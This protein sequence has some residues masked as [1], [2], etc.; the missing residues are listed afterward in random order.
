MNPKLIGAHPEIRCIRRS[1][2][3][4]ANSHSHI[5]IFGEPGVGK[6]LVGRLIHS[7]GPHRRL[8]LRSLNFALIT[9]RDQRIALFGS[10]PPDSITRRE[11]FVEAPTTCLLRNIEHALPHIQ[12][13]LVDA[14]SQREFRRT[15][16]GRVRNVQSRII[17]T[18]SEAD[19]RRPYVSRLIVPLRDLLRR[20]P[21]F[22]IPPLRERVQDIPLL[23]AHYRK[24]SLGLPNPALP[25][26]DLL[27]SP[28]FLR[29][30]PWRENITELKACLRTSLSHSHGDIL[31]QKERLEFEKLMVLLDEGE[32]FPLRHSTGIIESQIIQHVIAACGAHQ[33]QAARTLGLSTTTLQS[34][35]RRTT[36]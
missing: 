24:C 14:L 20:L 5:L 13:R 9:E 30:Y 19:F 23:A 17:F 28:D 6:T 12:Q 1:L 2:V 32:D 4:L 33:R 27:L 34:R 22:I 25:P 11:G 8:P 35:Q 36:D 26:D 3:A 10:E 31:C 15:P 7:L 16:S 18:T 29:I 21:K